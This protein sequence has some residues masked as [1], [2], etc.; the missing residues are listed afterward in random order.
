[1]KQKISLLSAAILSVLVM[2][3]NHDNS[4]TPDPTP[5]TKL[6]Y[7]KEWPSIKSAIPKN[8]NIEDEVANIV[9]QMTLEEKIGQMIQPDL[10]EI[11]PQEA[12]EYKIGSILNGGGAWPNNNKHASAEDWAKEA[13][14]YWLAVKGAYED[15]PFNIP[16]MWATDAVHGDNNVFRATVFPHNIGL[17][18]A[19]DP[20]LI[21]QIGAA[22]AE[23]ITATG[24]DWTFAPT[25]T[26]PRDYR[27]GRVYEG[28]SEDPE[29]VWKY[30]GKMVKGLQGDVEGLKSD[31]HV[32]SNV[33]HWVGDGGTTDGVDRGEN[34]YTEEYLRNIHATGYFSGLKAGAQVVMSSFNSWHNEANYDMDENDNITYNKKI[35]GSKYL[36]T[37]VLKNQLGFDGL[38][39]TDWNGQGEVSGCTASD[40]PAAVNAGNDIF[41][42]TSRADWQSFYNNTIEEV[43]KGIIPMERID[44]AVTRILRVKMRAGLWNKPMPSERSNAGNEGI[45]GSEAH[46]SIARKAV[47]ESLT[48]L[49]ND[50]NTLPLANDAQYLITGSAMDNIQKQTGGWSITWQGGEN[51]MDDFPG[52]QTML[53]ALKQQVGEENVT[54]DINMADTEKTTAIVVI[55]EDPYAEMMGDIKSSQTLD[56][57]TIKPSYKEDLETILDLKSR[58]FKVVTVFYS[59]RPLYVNEIINNSDAFIAAWLPGTEAGGITDVLFAKGGADFNG[60]LS[61]SWPNT[62]CS[63]TINRHAPNI[64]DYATP[65]MEQDIDGEH[66]PLFP[67]GYGLSYN[68]GSDIKPLTDDLDNLDLDP[69]NWGCGQDKPDDGKATDPLELFGKSSTQEYIAKIDGQANGWNAINVSINGETSI[70]SITTKPITREFQQDTLNVNFSGETDE[71]IDNSAAELFLEAPDGSKTDRNAYLNAEST[72]QFDVAM[73]EKAP[74]DFKLSMHCEWPCHGEVNISKVMPQP[75]TNP[76]KNDYTTIKIPLKCF[77]DSGENFANLNRPFL[78]YSTQKANFNIGNIRYVPKVVDAAEDA[79]PCDQLKDVLAQQ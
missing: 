1:M 49:K 10:R 9:S 32:L 38:V 26:T 59:G 52:A 57:S 71:F 76:G 15:R 5:K 29:I 79:I 68:G 33:K 78:I 25:V 6:P 7:Y 65:E 30:A 67:Y 4:V 36:I 74:E 60:R 19:H 46:R 42:V 24:L 18:A 27:W 66:A 21:E 3:C 44:D 62:K 48:L 23:E 53:M 43:N 11:T 16:F 37:D 28:Y 22:T 63:T 2:G 14:K 51:T 61:Y 58:G 8:Q 55:G 39:V 13:D 31:K 20:E 40:C 70:G 34:H 41:M 12:A 45:L 47:S 50:E 17:G 56:F 75:V 72:L 73:I 64:V 77:E 35:H 54:T 69:R